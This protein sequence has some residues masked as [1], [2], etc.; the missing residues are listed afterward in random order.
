MEGFQRDDRIALRPSERNVAS[1]IP[2]LLNNF[3]IHW[4]PNL[5]ISLTAV[6]MMS[7]RPGDR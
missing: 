1:H 2:L 7:E 3:P 5:L 6:T 4:D